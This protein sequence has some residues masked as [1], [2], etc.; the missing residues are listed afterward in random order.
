M[1]YQTL[2]TSCF[3]CSQNN[4]DLRSQEQLMAL[5]HFSSARHQL[6]ACQQM[7]LYS[8]FRILLQ[9]QKKTILIFLLYQSFLTCPVQLCNIRRT[10]LVL[11]QLFV[12]T[13][14]SSHLSVVKGA[15]LMKR[16]RQ[17]YHEDLVRAT[18]LYL[19]RT[20]GSSFS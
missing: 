4:H 19:S 20:N 6:S 14:A 16:F 15:C 7:I 18:K 1:Q 11:I 12:C 10:V 3:F 17:V 5:T 8:M 9:S 2:C 13:K